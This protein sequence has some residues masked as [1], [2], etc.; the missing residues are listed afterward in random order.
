MP[1]PVRIRDG[2]EW[3]AWLDAHHETA[4]EVWVVYWKKSTGRP[5]IVWAEAVEIALRYGWIDGLIRGID[6]ERYMQRWT[7]RRPKSK[8]SKV[9]REIALRLIAAGEMRPMGLA[10]VEAA[11]QSGEWARAYTAQTPLRAPADL[12]TAINASPEAKRTRDRVSR[13]RWDR[14]VTWLDGSEGRTRAR[15]INA[16]V[17]ALETRDYT[18]VDASAKRLE[19]Q[20]S[21]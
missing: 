1:E 10:A 15:R 4:S 21:K 16:I 19:R 5:S 13:T 2:D 17:K 8:W 20:R 14:W 3:T 6:D 18:A 9:N 7:P 12:R 11:K